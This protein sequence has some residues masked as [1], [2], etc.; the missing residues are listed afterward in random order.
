M[1]PRDP[2]A[3][4]LAVFKGLRNADKADAALPALIYLPGLHSDWTRISGF[5]H[6]LGGRVRLVE[7]PYGN[8]RISLNSACDWGVSDPLAVP[9]TALEMKKCGHLAAMIDTI[10][11]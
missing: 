8:E 7:V 2:L 3:K 5:R 4:D 10:S 6:A 9:K 1:R 11:Q